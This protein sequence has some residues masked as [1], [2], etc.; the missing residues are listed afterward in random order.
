[1][2]PPIYA[3]TLAP[4]VALSDA[5]GLVRTSIRRYP[6]AR[7][8]AALM[9]DAGFDA[10]RAQPVLGGLMAINCARRP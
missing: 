8:L 3:P 10:A 2:G 5:K 4:A 7:G 1:M 9:G 6:G